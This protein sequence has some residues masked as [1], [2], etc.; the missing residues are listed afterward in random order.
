[1]KYAPITSVGIC[2]HFLCIKHSVNKSVSFTNENLSKYMVVNFF[3]LSWINFS[4]FLFSFITGSWTFLVQYRLTENIVDWWR[5]MN[6]PRHNEL[7][8]NTEKNSRKASDIMATMYVQAGKLKTMAASLAGLMACWTVMQLGT[9]DSGIR[10]DGYNRPTVNRGG[11]DGGEAEPDE[12]LSSAI[13][14]FGFQQRE[15]NVTGRD[16]PRNEPNVPTDGEADCSRTGATQTVLRSNC[17][18]N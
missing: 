7:T 11:A 9:S 15:Q 16:Q 2:V 6:N 13:E 5:R 12:D 8:W 3:F 10:T 14:F 17:G 18:C 4:I 1:M